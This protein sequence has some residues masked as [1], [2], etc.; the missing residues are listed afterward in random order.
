MKYKQNI[1]LDAKKVQYLEINLLNKVHLLNINTECETLI[2]LSK[3]P[4]LFHSCLESDLFRKQ[5]A[6][7]RSQGN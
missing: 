4:F 7:V 5:T 2:L 6:V 3:Q 1:C